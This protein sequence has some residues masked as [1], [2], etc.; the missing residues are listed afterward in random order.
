IP[1]EQL[2]QQ[3]LT[4]SGAFVERRPDFVGHHL[5][6]GGED[7]LRSITKSCLVLLATRVGSD[8]LKGPAFEDARNF[9]LNGLETFYT[10]R[11]HMDAREIP[12]AT[13]IVAEYGELFNLIYVKSDSSGRVI[14]HFTLYNLVS[15]QIVLAESGSVPDIAI[16]LGS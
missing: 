4:G 1:L 8:A 7:A 14:G 2:K 11:I 6:F 5:S 15:W 9:V 13:G 10:T 16:A 3:I 12:C